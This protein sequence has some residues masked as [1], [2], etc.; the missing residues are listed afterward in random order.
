[1]PEREYELRQNPDV[2]DFVEA[3]LRLASK[4]GIRRAARAMEAAGVPVSVI[5]RVL[6]DTDQRRTP[7][8]VVVH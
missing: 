4:V 7:D 6:C 8:V 3:A 5:A 2:A 1:M